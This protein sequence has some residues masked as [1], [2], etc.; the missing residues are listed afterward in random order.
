MGVDMIPV[1]IGTTLG[2]LSQRELSQIS[3]SWGGA[4]D[5]SVQRGAG[6]GPA[7]PF[8]NV[9]SG[10]GGA[11]PGISG[12]VAAPNVRGMQ[13]GLAVDL[14]GINSGGI[15]LRATGAGGGN[16]QSWFDK[17][18]G[19]KGYFNTW[20]AR[21]W[22]RIGMG[23]KQSIGKEVFRIASGGRDQPYH[24][25]IDFEEGGVKFDFKR[26]G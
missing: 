11:G 10:G 25:H 24:I 22:V 2:N 5:G 20:W 16:G 6:P 15:M 1:L 12:S 21:S 17:L 18:F 26:K 7:S 23:W 19:R 8:S 4:L 3:Q 9:S 13:A 14:G